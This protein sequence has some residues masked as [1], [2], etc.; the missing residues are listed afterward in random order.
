MSDQRPE[1]CQCHHRGDPDAYRC[2][3]CP[4]DRREMKLKITDDGDAAGMNNWLYLAEE[5]DRWRNKALGFE[6]QL[7]RCRTELE[8]R[9][10]KLV[11]VAAE[12][13]RLREELA[14]G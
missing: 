3:A 1:F 10:S 13:D 9:G 5:L 14:D 12:R 8:H 6:N 2:E 11:E 4:K 7:V